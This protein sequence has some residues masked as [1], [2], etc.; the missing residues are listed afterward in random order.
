MIK[1]KDI[2]EKADGI[3]EELLY[4]IKTITSF[5][6]FDFEIR[7]Y[8]DLIDEMNNYDQKKLLIESIAYGLLYIASFG[9]IALVLVHVK[10]LK[11]NKEINYSSGL[12]YN[13]GELCPCSNVCFRLYLFSKWFRAK[14]S[15]SRKSMYCFK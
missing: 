8:N 1:S 3:A 9:S 11:I 10:S 6:N 14:F 5:C 2:N 7:R 12:P 13:S 4:N 15:I